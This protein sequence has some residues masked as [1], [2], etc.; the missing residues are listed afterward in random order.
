MIVDAIYAQLKQKYGKVKIGGAKAY[1]IACPTCDS[2]DQKK[3]KR[4]VS[5]FTGKSWCYICNEDLSSLQVLGDG[6]IP[7]SSTP[8]VEEVEEENP[9]ARI[10]P[11]SKFIPLHLLSDQHP[12]KLFLAKDFL[13]DYKKY[14]D[15]Y[16]II[17]CPS[18]G[19]KI[20][21]KFPFISSGDRLIFPVMFKGEFVGWQMRS[22][23]GT[24]YGD[25]D[26]VVKYYHLFPKGS[27]LYNY[28]QAI[29]YESVVVVEGVKKA[30]KFPNAVAT[31]GKGISPDQRQLLFNWKNITIMYDSEPEAQQ[32]GKDLEFSLRN[33]GRRALNINLGKYGIPSPDEAPAEQLESILA[34][35]WTAYLNEK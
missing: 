21:N 1:R 7:P 6:F 35:E 11:G 15:D 34:A 28:D 27:Y 14:Y 23:P 24:T 25:L 9:E 29:D 2:R 31:W 30:L 32:V 8:R 3:F 13:T 26:T 33:N 17:Y 18:D 4:Y 12:A 5:K 19:G 10:L 16:R 20:F 22:I